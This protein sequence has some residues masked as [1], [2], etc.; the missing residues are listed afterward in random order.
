MTTQQKALANKLKDKYF[1]DLFIAIERA[2]ELTEKIEFNNLEMTRDVSIELVKRCR[3][4]SCAANALDNLM[5]GNPPPKY[6]E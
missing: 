1:E 6:G 5:A 4:A 2:N 3:E